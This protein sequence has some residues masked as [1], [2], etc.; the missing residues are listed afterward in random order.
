MSLATGMKIKKIAAS[1]GTILGILAEI[2]H[3]YPTYSFL[4]SE[5][6]LVLYDDDVVE[7]GTVVK[8]K[9]GTAVVEFKKEFLRR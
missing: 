4:L 3:R 1:H 7:I 9:G 8:P 6:A 5:D 2:Y